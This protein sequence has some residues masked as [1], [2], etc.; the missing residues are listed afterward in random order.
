MFCHLISPFKREIITKD[1]NEITHIT[2]Y[3]ERTY[4]IPPALVKTDLCPTAKEK[5]KK[6]I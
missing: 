4:L 5:Y 1:T 6:Q 3:I 2:K